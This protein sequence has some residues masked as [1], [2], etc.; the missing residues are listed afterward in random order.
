MSTRSPT[1]PDTTNSLIINCYFAKHPE[2]IAKAL[3]FNRTLIAS[4]KKADETTINQQ[5]CVLLLSSR[6][7]HFW[8]TSTNGYLFEI[9]KDNVVVGIASLEEPFK[10]F[11]SL[12]SNNKTLYIYHSVGNKYSRM[13]IDNKMKELREKLV[14]QGYRISLLV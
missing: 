8:F 2:K 5:A 3:G 10:R 9:C 14:S 6:Y 11:S 12:A 1:S 7:G 4:I 13:L